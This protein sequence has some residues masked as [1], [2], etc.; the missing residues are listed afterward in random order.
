AGSALPVLA[1]GLAVPRIRDVTSQGLGAV[2]LKRGAPADS[3]RE[4]DMENVVI[5]PPNTPIPAKRSQTF[6][7]LQ[8]RQRRLKVEVTQ[9]D[10]HDPCYVRRIGEQTL[11]IPPY[12]KGA[13]FEIVY[14]Y[15][16]DQTVFIEVIDKTTGDLVGTFEVR[17]VANMNEDE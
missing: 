4:S 7:T 5:I 12:P 15:D 16:V 9:G 13:P 1:S 11:E 2:A 3:D 10:D 14:A 6:E 17:N 8:D